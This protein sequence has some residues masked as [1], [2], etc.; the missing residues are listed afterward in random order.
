MKDYLVVGINHKTAP[1]ALRESLAFP[2]NSLPD[3]LSRLLRINA[4]DEALILS[5]CNRVEIYAASDETGTAA[6]EISE[7]LSNGRGLKR[8]DLERYLYTFHAL[9]AVRH[10][11]RVASSLDSMVIGETQIV[12]QVKRA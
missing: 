7:F 1:I 12:S 8:G 10:G 5:T 11:F 4:V 2:E 3:A 9:D 6:G